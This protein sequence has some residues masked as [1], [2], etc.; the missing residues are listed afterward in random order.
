MITRTINHEMGTEQ[1]VITMPKK[2]TKFLD[3]IEEMV[4]KYEQEN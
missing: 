2:D 1:L 4:N 3:Y